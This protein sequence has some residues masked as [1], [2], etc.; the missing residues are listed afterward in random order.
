VSEPQEP[1]RRPIRIGP[2]EFAGRWA[3]SVELERSPHEFTLDMIRMDPKFL[4]GQVVS[5][6]SFSPLLLMEL[7]DLVNA[8]WGRYTG[9]AGVPPRSEEHDE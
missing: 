1:E 2:D 7:R 8:V 6:V 3:N 9:E 4:K 5:R